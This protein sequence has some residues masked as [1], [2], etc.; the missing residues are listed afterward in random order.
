LIKTLT[1]L[2]Y[3]MGSP[4]GFLAG[5]ANQRIDIDVFDGL[6]VAFVPPVHATASAG[7]V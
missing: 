7:A 2:V 4:H 5:I 3:R 1:V 6:T